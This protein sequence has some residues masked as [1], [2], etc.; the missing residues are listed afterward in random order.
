MCHAWPINAFCGRS[1]PLLVRLEVTVVVFL[2][3]DDAALPPDLL[4]T[5]TRP[6]HRRRMLVSFAVVL[7]SSRSLSSLSCTPPTAPPCTTC[8]PPPPLIWTD[9]DSDVEFDD[10][11]PAA[12]VGCVPQSP[13]G[14]PLLL[15]FLVVTYPPR[16]PF[17][18][19][20]RRYSTSLCLCAMLADGSF[21]YKNCRF[22]L[23]MCSS[24]SCSVCSQF[25]THLHQDDRC[26]QL[27]E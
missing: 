17:S 8:S 26:V 10:Y 15:A 5:M 21:S 2:S 6:S 7:P 14:A 9:D 20:A 24:D 11:C 27:M 12:P 16:S 13:A 22:L 4:Y 18:S 19:E 1:Q 25:I 3:V 23:C